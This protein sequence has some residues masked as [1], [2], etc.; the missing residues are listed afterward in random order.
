MYMAATY[1]TNLFRK[2]TGGN[3]V[4][5]AATTPTDTEVFNGYHIEISPSITEAAK[6]MLH[7]EGCAVISDIS[8]TSKILVPAQAAERLDSGKPYNRNNVDVI[9]S[10][11]GED[12][13]EDAIAARG[14]NVAT[15]IMT[16]SEASR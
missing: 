14:I 16:V 2:S 10:P 13:L 3:I 4:A 9:V 6:K 11:H 8:D 15:K 12:H 5:S 1:H 7:D